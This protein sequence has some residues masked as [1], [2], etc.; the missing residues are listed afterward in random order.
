MSTNGIGFILS[1]VIV[2]IMAVW[3]SPDKPMQ[4]VSSHG[5]FIVIL[6][7]AAIAAISVPIAELKRFFAMVKVVAKKELEDRIEI[8]NTF[9]EMAAKVR[10]DVSQI[11]AFADQVKEPFFRDAIVLL[12][13]GFD[14][15]SMVRILR[16]RLE[17]QKERENA[18]A[19]MFKNLG[20]YPP[21]CGL[22]GTVMGMIALLGS[23]GQ[24]GAAESIG[25]SMSVA[26]AATL[27]GVIL[28]NMVVLPVA[29]NLLAR[30]AKSIAKRE[31]IVEGILLLKQKTNPVMVREMLL[32]HLPPALREQVQSGGG[33]K[34]V[35]AS[36]A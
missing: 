26:L 23:L 4:Y 13:Q 32:S 18:H 29:D 34:G 9:V 31:M 19:M 7:T 5:A 21:A 10:A 16:R 1:I 30:T 22:L 35:S 33:S 17:V 3:T 36:A 12:S 11:G 20:K 8:V 15:D 28:A 2:V 14:A 25:P 6:G 24:E 27:Y